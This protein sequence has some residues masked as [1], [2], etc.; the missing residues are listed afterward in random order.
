MEHRRRAQRV[1]RRALSALCGRDTSTFIPQLGNYNQFNQVMGS[2]RDTLLAPSLTVKAGLGFADLTSI[3]S[4]VGRRVDRYTDGTYFNTSAIAEYYLD[5]AGVP[6]YSDH[7]HEKRL[8]PRQYTL[9][10]AVHGAVQ[11]LD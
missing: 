4:Y 8:H 7:T 5:S 3:T 2:D 11:H 10:R 6:P 9:A 1:A